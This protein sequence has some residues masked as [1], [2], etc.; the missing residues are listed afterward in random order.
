VVPGVIRQVLYNLIANAIDAL[1]PSGTLT[2]STRAAHTAEITVADTGHGISPENQQRIFEP[3]FTTKKQAGTGLGLW[4]SNQLVAKNGGSI[5]V[6]SSTDAAN[7]GTA[8]TVHLPLAPT[9]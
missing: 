5:T 2:V 7:H 4:V 9:L 8:I 3:F 6:N 1:G